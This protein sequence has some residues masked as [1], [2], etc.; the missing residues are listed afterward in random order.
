MTRPVKVVAI[1][2]PSGSGK[3]SVS[4]A[5]ASQL[6]WD[7][8]DTGA[9]YRAMTAWMLDRGVDVNDQDAVAAASPRPVPVIATDPRHA[10]VAVDGRDVTEVIRGSAV[11]AAV[12]AVSSVQEV[13]TRLVEMQRAAVQAALAAGRGIVVEGRDI[14]TVVL[15]EADLKIFLTASEGERARR[16]QAEFSDSAAQVDDATASSRGTDGEVGRTAESMAR[17]DHAD[18]TRATSPL[19]RADDAVVI[20]AT[21]L[22]LV[23]VVARVLELV[24]DRG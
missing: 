7:Y 16:R 23:D 5:V 15:P 19:A 20:D 10:A 8:L 14:G 18:S 11:T 24:H 21:D 9:M 2:G 22:T 1:D 6:G 4:R 12:S 13:R 3:S 17:R